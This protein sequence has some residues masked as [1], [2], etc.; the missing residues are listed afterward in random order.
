MPGDKLN[1]IWKHA[2]VYVQNQLL[3]YKGMYPNS[4]YDPKIASNSFRTFV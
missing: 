2:A 4:G 1:S 3:N